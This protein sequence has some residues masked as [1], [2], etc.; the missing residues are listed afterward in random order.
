[1]YNFFQSGHISFKNLS[2]NFKRVT[3]YHFDIKKK[4]KHKNTNI[5]NEL[6]SHL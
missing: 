5:F 3:I 6:V 1:M 2:E 4:L